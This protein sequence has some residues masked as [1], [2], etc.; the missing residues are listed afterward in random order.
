[1]AELKLPAW[2]GN[3]ES[4]TPSSDR[5]FF[6]SRSLLR[7]MGI[8]FQIRRQAKINGRS[9]QGAAGRMLFVGMVVLLTVSARTSAFLLLVLAGELVRLCFLSGETI[10]IILRNALAAMFFSALVLLPSLFWGAAPAVV[11][12]PMK[13]FLTVA[14]LSI[15]TET[16]P[17]HMLTASLR[18]F[19]VPHIFIQ[20]LDITLKYIV[21]LGEVSLQMLYALKLRS[22]GRNPAKSKAFSGVLG[23]TFLKSRELS[24]EMYAA[25]VCRCFTGEY[26]GLSRSFH[27]RQDAL[28]A[29]GALLLLAFYLYCEGVFL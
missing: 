10:R 2:A 6:I 17:W 28:L 22:V 14:A 11:L 24:E 9:R 3:E 12:I 8:L 18:V 7:L 27:S 5:D 20:I 15:L 25:M 29:V 23:G 26:P 13:T 16:L 19:R 4:Y 1:M 21:L